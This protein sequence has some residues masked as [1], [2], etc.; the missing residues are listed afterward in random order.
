[1]TSV[2]QCCLVTLEITLEAPAFFLGNLRDKQETNVVTQ[3]FKTIVWLDKSY[4]MVSNFA[5]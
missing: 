1:M 5:W 2:L 3:H 4:S